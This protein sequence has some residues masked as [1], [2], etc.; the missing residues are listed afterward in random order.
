MGSQ[1]FITT[2]LV[3]HHNNQRQRTTTN[4]LSELSVLILHFKVV[5]ALARPSTEH[6]RYKSVQTR[7]VSSLFFLCLCADKHTQT[8]RDR[9]AH[10]NTHTHDTHIYNENISADLHPRGNKEEKIEKAHTSAHV[11]TNTQD[12]IHA[13]MHAYTQYL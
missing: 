5:W 11:R 7:E 2:I 6:I 9:H 10:T 12:H 1:I 8:H 3:F 4:K 13:L